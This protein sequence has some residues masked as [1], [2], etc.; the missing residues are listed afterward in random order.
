V[1]VA[2]LPASANVTAL[3]N[4]VAGVLPIAVNVPRAGNSFRFVRPLVVDE[5]TKLTF[6]YRQGK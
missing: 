2:D 3:Q 4:R 1:A 5:E 6:N